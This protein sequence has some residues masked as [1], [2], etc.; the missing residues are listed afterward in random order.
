[1]LIMMLTAMELSAVTC[2]ADPFARAPANPLLTA[3]DWPYQVSAVFNPAA[4]IV[5]AK[6]Y[7][8]VASR[9]ATAT[10]I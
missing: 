2:P 10:R 6:L 7:C 4:A 9:I 5:E 8:R 3:A 1:M